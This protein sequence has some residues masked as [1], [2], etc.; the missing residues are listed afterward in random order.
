[1]RKSVRLRIDV[2]VRGESA[3]AADFAARAARAVRD[4]LAAGRSAHPDLHV[5]LRHVADADDL[6]DEEEPRGED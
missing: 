4:V 1:M 3:P 2:E 6:A 5:V